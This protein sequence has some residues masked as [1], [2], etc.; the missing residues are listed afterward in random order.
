MIGINSIRLQS[1]H[2]ARLRD[3]S[4]LRAVETVSQ[5]EATN[6]ASQSD[7][8]RMATRE[9]SRDNEQVPLSVYLSRAAKYRGGLKKSKKTEESKPECPVEKARSESRTGANAPLNWLIADQYGGEAEFAPTAQD[10]VATEAETPKAPTAEQFTVQPQ[11]SEAPG[12]LMPQ[13]WL[14]TPA[15]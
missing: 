3:L 9:R 4:N 13:E 5:D 8:I 7:T 11:V 10:M 12:S 1:A 15:L 6:G 2:A 14:L